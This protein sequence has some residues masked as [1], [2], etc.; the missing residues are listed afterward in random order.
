MAYALGYRS[1]AAPRLARPITASLNR[2]INFF[3]REKLPEDARALSQL[4]HSRRLVLFAV[5]RI[6]DGFGLAWPGVPG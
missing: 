3:E 1:S 6:L 2:W 5:F 4:F